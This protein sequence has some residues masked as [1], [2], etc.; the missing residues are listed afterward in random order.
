MFGNSRRNT[1][2]V[3]VSVICFAWKRT[4]NNKFLREYVEQ[5]VVRE[6]S[7]DDSER[8]AGNY[9]YPGRRWPKH[10]NQC[11]ADSDMMKLLTLYSYPDIRQQM[12]I[13]FRRLCELLSEAYCNREWDQGIYI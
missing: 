11:W 10:S 1:T 4:L 13:I 3:Q 8:T 12:P 9:V 7:E 2:Q 6:S 5:Y